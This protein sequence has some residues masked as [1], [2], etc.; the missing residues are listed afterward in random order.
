MHQSYQQTTGRQSFTPSK[1]ERY[2]QY[3]PRKRYV[4]EQ[5][6]FSQYHS[7]TFGDVSPQ[8]VQEDNYVPRSRQLNS[9]RRE[10]NQHN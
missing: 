7:V 6:E 2:N 5:E 4:K 10:V 8:G 1:R 3:T 9:S